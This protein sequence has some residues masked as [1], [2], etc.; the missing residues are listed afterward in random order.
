MAESID[1]VRGM[2]RCVGRSPGADRTELTEDVAERS[3]SAAPGGLGELLLLGLLAISAISATSALVISGNWA[4]GWA[5]L[6]GGTGNGAFTIREM[7]DRFWEGGAL[8][9]DLGESGLWEEG[10]SS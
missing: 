2:M 7:G 5:E 8:A 4:T 3:G 10:D 9:L 1:E 6:E